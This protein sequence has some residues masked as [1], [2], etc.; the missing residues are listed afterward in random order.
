VGYKYTIPNYHRDIFGTDDP[1]TGDEISMALFGMDGQGVVEKWVARGRPGKANDY[2]TE[3][4]VSRL[5]GACTKPG[6]QF[7]YKNNKH[8]RLI[9]LIKKEGIR[10]P[11]TVTRISTKNG[12]RYGILKGH[13]R[14]GAALL[15][16]IKTVP[17]FVLQ[18]V[19]AQR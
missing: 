16:G 10:Y 15:L 2:V 13:H 3:I 12:V 14:A 6:W 1:K 19:E 9:E 8:V 5:D 11:L 4:E 7:E 18:R 17:A